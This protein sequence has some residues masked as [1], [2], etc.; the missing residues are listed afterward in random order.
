M[1]AP[2]FALPPKT[3]GGSVPCNI[4][5]YKGPRGSAPRVKDS[6]FIGRGILVASLVGL[7]PRGDLGSFWSY[8]FYIARKLYR[9]NRLREE[10][11]RTLPFYGSI[12][13]CFDPEF[14]NITARCYPYLIM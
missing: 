6:R 7:N 5:P 4:M 12:T 14:R 9:F 13:V 10:I 11:K 8:R 2:A 3:L 1:K